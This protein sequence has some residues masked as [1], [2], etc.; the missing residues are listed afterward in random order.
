VRAKRAPDSRFC[1]RSAPRG[2]PI[3]ARASKR[4]G[5]KSKTASIEIP[6]IF[7]RARLARGASRQARARARVGSRSDTPHIFCRL[8]RWNTRRLI[9]VLVLA[10]LG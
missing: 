2:R 3:A 5:I 4:Q 1:A 8:E 7:R 10:K 9:Q 6:K